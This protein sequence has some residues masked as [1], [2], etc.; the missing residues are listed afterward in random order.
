MSEQT[1]PTK[2]ELNR[3]KSAPVEGMLRVLADRWSPPRF[4]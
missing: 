2:E 3:K 4:F 1:V